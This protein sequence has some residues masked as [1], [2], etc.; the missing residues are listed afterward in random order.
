M[1]EM[2]EGTLFNA[3]NGGS[4]NAPFL[5]FHRFRAALSSSASHR[6]FSFFLWATRISILE[7]FLK[8]HCYYMMVSCSH[9]SRW[10]ENDFSFFSR[11]FT[12]FFFLLVKKGSKND[13]KISCWSSTNSRKLIAFLRSSPQLVT[14][15][16]YKIRTTSIHAS[17]THTQNRARPFLLLVVLSLCRFFGISLK[18]SLMMFHNDTKWQGNNY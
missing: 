11:I 1:V 15:R 8:Y 3:F 9:S 4:F 2:S 14:P 7:T 18:R 10:S 17:H 16:A 5:P 6:V 13:E 12:L